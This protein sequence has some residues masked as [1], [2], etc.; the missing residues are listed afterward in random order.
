MNT[1]ICGDL[2][3]IAIGIFETESVL[4]SNII[5]ENFASIHHIGSTAVRG[6]V[7]KPQIDIALEIEN[8]NK[9]LILKNH[10]YIYKGEFNIPFRYFFSGDS[11]K[12]IKINLHVVERNS[13]ELEGFIVFR[14]YMR[15]NPKACVEYS[16]LKLQN[17]KFLESDKKNEYGLGKYTLMKDGFIR[18]ILKKAGFEGLCIRFAAHYKELE[19]VGEMFPDTKYFV[20]YKGPDLVGHCAVSESDNRVISFNA[21]DKNYAKYFMEK[22]RSYC[23]IPV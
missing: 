3:D 19:Y 15:D 7:A 16:A 5:G 1:Y 13:P 22:V 21:S 17:S 6:L 10:G 2:Y 18:K 4:I 9:S 12:N 20:F 14:D 8:L 11:K 23:G